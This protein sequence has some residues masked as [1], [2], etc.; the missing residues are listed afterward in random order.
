M[1]VQKNYMMIFRFN[2]NAEQAKDN[3]IL[4]TQHAD[5]GKFIGDIAA[6]ERL[7]ST[8]QL[9]FEGKTISCTKEVSEGVNFDSGHTM[10]GNMVV[11]AETINEAVEMAKESPIIKLG[12][13]VEVRAINPM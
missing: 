9:G 10:G 4:A 12:G 3:S 13:N 2:P 11:L 8:H 1:T 6:K 5:W 7:V